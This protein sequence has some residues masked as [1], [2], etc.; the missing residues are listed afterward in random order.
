MA[1]SHLILKAKDGGYFKTRV[2]LLF[3]CASLEFHI[4]ELNSYIDSFVLFV[5][6]NRF[7]S[8]KSFLGALTLGYLNL[9]SYTVDVYLE[10]RLTQ[11]GR[12]LM[13]NVVSAADSA[14]LVKGQ[15]HLASPHTL[16]IHE[17][18]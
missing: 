11:Q 4:R 12:W 9:R 8:V 2:S 18:P 1:T 16:W 6:V 3:F 10:S 14:A 13:C 5:A 17:L 15:D 7:S